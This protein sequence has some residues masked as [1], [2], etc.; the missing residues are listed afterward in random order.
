M[1]STSRFS[2]RCFGTG[3]GMPCGDRNHSS[4]L[5]QLGGATL[6]LDCGE[7]V[8]RHLKASGLSWDLIDQIVLSHFHF[9]HVGGFFLLMQGMW[10]EKRRKSLPVAMPRDGLEPVRQMLN[11]GMIF[12]ELLAFKLS[13]APLQAG[14]P[15]EVGQARVTPF[16]TT[17]LTGLKRQF[18]K[19]Y[20]LA[21]EAFCFLLEAEGV[22]IGHSADLGQ[23]SDL[24]PVVAEPLDL[25]LCELAHFHPEDLFAYLQGHSI[26][27]LV[28]THLGRPQQK[29]REAIRKNAAKMLPKCRITFAEDLD[30]IEI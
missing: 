19:K 15:L 13:L 26:K 1:E 14:K 4:F 21:F 5:Y 7:P 23:P 22:R 10:L 9:D 28:L 8:S 27:H 17:H 29:R 30:L 18:Q 16:P 6:L 25:L 11:V 20:P 12:E 24:D 2:L 3:D